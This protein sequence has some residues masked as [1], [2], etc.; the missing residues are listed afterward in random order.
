MPK[1]DIA[2]LSG[3]GRG[4]AGLSRAEAGSSHAQYSLTTAY[5]T[6]SAASAAPSPIREQRR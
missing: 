3:R 2:T 4:R 1:I 5:M 6:R